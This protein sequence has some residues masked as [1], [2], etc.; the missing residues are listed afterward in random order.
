MPLDQVTNEQVEN[1]QFQDDANYN[2]EDE[3]KD[4][5]M[6]ILDHLEELRW[7]LIRASIA[8][9]VFTILAFINIAWIFENLILAPAKTDFWTYH[10]FCDIGKYMGTKDLCITKIAFDLQ[11]R[12]MTGQFMMS[13]T[14]SWVIGLIIAFPYVFWEIWQF[15]KPGL[16]QKEKRAARGAVFWVTCLFMCGVLFGYYLLAPLSINFLA[17]YTISP[18]IKNQFDI[19]SYISTV[20][21]LV[22][23]CGFLFQ[24]PI[25]VYFLATIEIITAKFMRK[26]RRHAIVLILIIAGIITP[27]DV[28]SQIMV[29]MPLWILYE[30]SINIA[31]NVEKKIAKQRSED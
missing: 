16:Y 28:F 5:E 9:G 12:N 1:Y 15:V 2:K 14:A 21:T 20:M 10:F 26:Y 7:H 27:P 3:L 30:I 4:S 25:L 19:V 31:K 13:M 11:S 22:V 23:G 24:L 18:L 17:N 8:I 6:S 29:S